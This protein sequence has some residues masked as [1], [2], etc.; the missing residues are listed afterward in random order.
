MGL[1]SDQEIMQLVGSDP[2]FRDT[3]A[4]SLQECAAEGVYTEVRASGLRRIMFREIN[5]SQPSVF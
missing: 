3:F 4:P 1:E 5:H 2:K